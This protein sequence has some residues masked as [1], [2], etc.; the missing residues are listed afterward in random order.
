VLG[1]AGAGFAMW[2]DLLF[3]GSSLALAVAAAPV[4]DMED[5]IIAA[6][7]AVVCGV[8]ALIV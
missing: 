1:V 6:C 5:R 2:P 4:S 7:T 3:C 8:L